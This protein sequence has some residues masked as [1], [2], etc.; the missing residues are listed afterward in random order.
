MRP[1]AGQTIITDCTWMPMV[2]PELYW[3]GSVF[4]VRNETELA[5][6]QAQAR[7]HDIHSAQRLELDMCTLDWLNNITALRAENPG[8]ITL[9]PLQLD[10]GASPAAGE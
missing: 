5:A 8:G 6:W 2:I 1:L 9:Q 3:Q 7:A 10:A 4:I